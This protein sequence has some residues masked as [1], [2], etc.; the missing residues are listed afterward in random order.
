MSRNVKEFITI[1]KVGS[2]DDLIASL[3]D[4]RAALPVGAN[5]EVRLRG[6]DTW[7]RHIAVSYFRPQTEEESACEARYA[8]IAQRMLERQARDT[9]GRVRAVA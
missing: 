7:G 3:T 1:D 2:L 5:S 6:C 9:G 8:E 4:L